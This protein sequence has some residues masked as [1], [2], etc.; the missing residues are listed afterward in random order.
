MKVSMSMK[1]FNR[2]ETMTK[3]E[4][5]REREKDDRTTV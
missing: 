5:G 2:L 4:G 1:T 3:R